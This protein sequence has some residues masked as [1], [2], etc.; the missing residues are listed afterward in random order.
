MQ[1][2]AL[3]IRDKRTA[4]FR[5]RPKHYR[6]S[7]VV[8]VATA[9]VILLHDAWLVCVLATSPKRYRVLDR[10]GISTNWLQDGEE[11]KISH[12]RRISE[13]TLTPRL[14]GSGWNENFGFCTEHRS[15]EVSTI[16]WPCSCF[17]GGVWPVMQCM[18]SNVAVIQR[19]GRCVTVVYPGTAESQAHSPFGRL[20]NSDCKSPHLILEIIKRS[21]SSRH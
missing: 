19:I 20:G 18:S 7:N 3:G 13:V 4:C 16:I 17:D 14:V 15:M 1:L 9:I 2:V 5:I 12:D 11:N 21:R 8:S 6:R 10:K